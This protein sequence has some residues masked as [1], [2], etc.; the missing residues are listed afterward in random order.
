MVTA[1]EVKSIFNKLSLSNQ[2]NLLQELLIEQELQ[3]KVLL[4]AKQEVNQK[5]NKKPCP[6]CS[7][8]K[9]HKRGKQTGVQMYHC[10]ACLKWYSDITGTALY[11]IK[12][13]SKWQAY[14][15]CM[16]RNLDKKDI[17]GAGYKYSN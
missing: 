12:L 9:A 14:I 17:Q 16:E 10:T 15:T 5:R 7:S 8:E 11:E 1:S 4:E 2:N 13:K 3:G 6:H